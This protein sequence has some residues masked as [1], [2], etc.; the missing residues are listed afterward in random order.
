MAALHQETEVCSAP[1]RLGSVESWLAVKLEIGGLDEVELTRWAVVVAGQD[2]TLVV[3][4]TL[5]VVV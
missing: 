1:K 4:E 3:A 5:P 2:C